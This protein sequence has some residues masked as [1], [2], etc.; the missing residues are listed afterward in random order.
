[1]SLYDEHQYLHN[2][3]N[4]LRYG[5]VKK[6]GR[7]G[8]TKELIGVS[9]R[10]NLRNNVLPL[11]TTKFVSYKTVLKELLFF[12]NG[13]TDNRILQ[14]QGVKIW[15]GNSSREFLDN[16]DLEHYQEGQ[17]GPIYGFQWRN[18]N[19]NYKPCNCSDIDEC[20]CSYTLENDENRC[21]QLQHAIDNLKNPETR[22]SRQ[23]VISAWNPLQIGDMVLPP[24]HVMFQFL[25]NSRDELYCILTQRS[26]DM[27]L[28]IPYNI[29]S[30]SFLTH[31]VA[32]HC[33]LNVGYLI[34]NI[35]SAHIYK[36]HYEALW[37]Q[38]NRLPEEPPKLNILARREKIE[39]YVLEDFEVVDYKHQG[40][41]KMQMKP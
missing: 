26:A 24:C 1:M 27:G 32:H 11:L 22:Y 30:Y 31:L 12:I 10:F 17:L 39:D 5:D 16:N 6:N 23:I 8:E 28:G 36:E 34:I 9:M 21:D 20:N 40:N 3:S 19:G 41:V 35:G 37:E 13:Y 33:G 15:N 4:I 29:A 2:C 25:V 38:I 7:N 18:F 14:R